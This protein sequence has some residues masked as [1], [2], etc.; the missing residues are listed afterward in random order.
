MIEEFCRQ[1]LVKHNSG[2]V[3]DLYLVQAHI[4]GNQCGAF[5]GITIYNCKVS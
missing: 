3:A 1:H 5:G 2:Q 4:L